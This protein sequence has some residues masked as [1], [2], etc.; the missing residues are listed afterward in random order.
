MTGVP[1]LKEPK[2]RSKWWSRKMWSSP[3][4]T[5]TSKIH[6]RVEQFSLKT[7]CKSSGRKTAILIQLRL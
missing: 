4:A 3:P 6:L 2:E 7:N 5:N 1:G